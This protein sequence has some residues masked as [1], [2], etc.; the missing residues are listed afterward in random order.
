M[1]QRLTTNVPNKAVA[2]LLAVAA[3]L[4]AAAATAPVADAGPKSNPKP[5]GVFPEN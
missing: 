4:G 1:P 3:L 5:G 2:V